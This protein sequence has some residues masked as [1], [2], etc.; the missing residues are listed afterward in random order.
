MDST[1]QG[2]P[3]VG[4]F[5]PA[6]HIQSRVVLSSAAFTGAWR[7]ER[8]EVGGL[9][10]REAWADLWENKLKTSLPLGVTRSHRKIT[11]VRTKFF[12]SVFF[13]FL[14]NVSKTNLVSV[15][16]PSVHSQAFQIRLS[17]KPVLI[18]H[19]IIHSSVKGVR[20]A[21]ESHRI[22]MSLYF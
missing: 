8:N 20:F 10:C 15:Y 16:L 2:A 9:R 14:Q 4:T 12:C 13:F 21:Q 17:F 5:S 18:P 7:S 1:W 11:T 19:L 6:S 22:K 3:W